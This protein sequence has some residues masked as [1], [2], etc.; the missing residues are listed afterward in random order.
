MIYFIIILISVLIAIF[1]QSRYGLKIIEKNLILKPFLFAVSLFID[2]QKEKNHL[3]ADSKKSL[4]KWILGLDIFFFSKRAKV[5][6]VKIFNKIRE[7]KE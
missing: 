1:L 4:A 2:S 5:E 6:K 7:E 3:I